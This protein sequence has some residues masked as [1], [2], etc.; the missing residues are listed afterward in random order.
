MLSC[1]KKIFL[2]FIQNIVLEI[3]ERDYGN[4]YTHLFPVCHPVSLDLQFFFE[5]RIESIKC[6]AG[7]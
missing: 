5:L 1:P 7:H 3:M 4:D 2:F 6:L